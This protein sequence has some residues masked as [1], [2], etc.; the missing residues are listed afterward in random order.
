LSYGG[1]Q[2]DYTG[3]SVTVNV[4]AEP[5]SSCKGGAPSLLSA[6]TRGGYGDSM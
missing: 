3:R 5:R 4:C 2:L 6:S 1:L